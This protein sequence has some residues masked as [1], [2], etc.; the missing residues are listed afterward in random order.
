MRLKHPKAVNLHFMIFL[1]PFFDLWY[2]APELRADTTRKAIFSDKA[3]N[4]K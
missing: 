2:L 3:G 4:V 1:P